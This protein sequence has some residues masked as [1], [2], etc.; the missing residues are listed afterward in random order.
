MAAVTQVR[1]L[2]SAFLFL[3]FFYS[4]SFFILLIYL[5]FFFFSF[6]FLEFSCNARIFVS[7]LGRNRNSAS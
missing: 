4:F 6:F 3:S 2:V 5:N 1:I 7:V